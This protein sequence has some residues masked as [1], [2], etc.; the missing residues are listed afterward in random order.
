MHEFFWWCV[1]GFV[2]C[3]QADT[4]GYVAL[5]GYRQSW[6]TSKYEWCGWL[7]LW[8]RINK[9]SLT[10]VAISYTETYRQH[11][12]TA[13]RINSCWFTLVGFHITSCMQHIAPSLLV[14]PT[15]QTWSKDFT[16]KWDI[17]TSQQVWKQVWALIQ[18]ASLILMQLSLILF[19]FKNDKLSFALVSSKQYSQQHQ[20][21][22]DLQP[23]SRVFQTLSSQP[24]Q[25]PCFIILVILY[26]TQSC[27][28]LQLIN[29]YHP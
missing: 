13:S 10:L 22:W 16:S 4:I 28:S 6:I 24:E 27:H 1:S 25:H 11:L 21:E 12:T 20:R 15:C 3:V 8:T 19:N 23:I 7:S 14:A 29:T 5:I 9:K 26:T 2:I 18:L 17:P